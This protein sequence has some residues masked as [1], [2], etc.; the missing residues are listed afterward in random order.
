[1]QPEI[2]REGENSL[3]DLLKMSDFWRTNSVYHVAFP[4][5]VMSRDR[6]MAVLSNLHM[7]DPIEDAINDQKK[8]TGE[9]DCPHQF[10][11]L[12]DMLRNCCMSVYQPK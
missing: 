6:F 4:S 2:C 8:G 3:L 10:R 1:M 11:P 12:L 9:Y 5:T 7:S